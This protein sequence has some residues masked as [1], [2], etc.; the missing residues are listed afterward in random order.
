MSNA[1]TLP[2]SHKISPWLSATWAEYLQRIENP[3][4]E[5]ERVFFHLNTI[6]IDMGNEGINHSRFNELFTLIFGFW[7]SQ[8][9]NVKFD[10]LGGCVLE[11]PKTQSAAPDKVLYI[12]GEAPR[13]QTGEPRRVNLD[14]WR[15]PDLVAEIADTTLPIDLDEKKQLYLALG[16]P[17]YWVIDVRGRQ[18]WAFQLIAGKYQE[19]IESVALT[20]LPIDLLEQTLAKMDDDNGN[21]ALWFADQIKSLPPKIT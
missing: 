16:I 15:V 17:E 19:C 6:W 5:S 21:V 7:F 1:V 14:R 18:I 12:G 9:A 3:Q 4:S 20:G 2:Q 13:W 8:Q 11:K 10:L